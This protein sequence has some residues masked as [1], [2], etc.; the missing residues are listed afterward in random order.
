MVGWV[1][2]IM[3]RKA[4]WWHRGIQQNMKAYSITMC[5][6][7][8]SLTNL[9]EDWSIALMTTSALNI[10]LFLSYPFPTDGWTEY[11]A[12]ENT[13][14]KREKKPHDSS[15]EAYL[16]CMDQS[17]TEAGEHYE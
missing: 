10:Y 7:R 16:I 15:R 14:D 5:Y 4:K 3:S 13:S 1:S 12:K 17:M 11:E 2:S 8:R 6:K 9:C